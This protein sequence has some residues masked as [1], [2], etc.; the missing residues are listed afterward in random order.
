MT[1]N[2]SHKEEEPLPPYA[3]P[4]AKE[5]FSPSASVT[6]SNIAEACKLA[7]VPKLSGSIG[8]CDQFEKININEI[9]KFTRGLIINVFGTVIPYGQEELN[10]NIAKKIEELKDA[11]KNRICFISENNYIPAGLMNTGIPTAVNLVERPD[12]RAFST[13]SEIYLSATDPKRC[14]YIGSNYLLDNGALDSRMH[15]IN[16][17]HLRGKE[18]KMY[19]LLVS[20]ANRISRIHAN[21]QKSSNSKKSAIPGYLLER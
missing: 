10:A 3:S 17:P 5:R 12:K 2:L 16:V 4:Y 1:K 13:T 9:S 19:R 18:S 7:V 20:T 6:P 8:F 14:T 21:M 15:Y 11:F